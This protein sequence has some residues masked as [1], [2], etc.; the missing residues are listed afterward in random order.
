MESAGLALVILLRLAKVSPIP[1]LRKWWHE[2]V[3]YVDALHERHVRILYIYISIYIYIYMS[4]YMYI[5]THL[6][7]YTYIYT[8]IY[9]YLYIFIRP[10]IN[11][12]RGTVTA[13]YS[14]CYLGYA[15]LQG[16][17]SDI[18]GRHA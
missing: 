16:L 13:A 17:V 1:F 7:I 15:K 5:Y 14:S 8:Y 4:I 6:F 10:L 9:I 11:K 18:P 12:K 2:D 3:R